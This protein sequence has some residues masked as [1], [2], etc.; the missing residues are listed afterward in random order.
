MLRQILI[1]HSSDAVAGEL[2]GVITA[3]VSDAS[4]IIADTVEQAIETIRMFNIHLILFDVEAADDSLV[5]TYHKVQ[6]AGSGKITPFLL[7]TEQNQTEEVED[8][9]NAG[10]NGCLKLPCEDSDLSWQIDSLCN[11]ERLRGAKRYSIPRTEVSVAQGEHHLSGR[12]VNISE[13]GLLCQLENPANFDWT[14]PFNLGF[15]FNNDVVPQELVDIS[16]ILVSLNVMRANPDNTPAQI[17]AAFRF[18]NVCPM[19]KQE[20]RDIFANYEMEHL[21]IL[22]AM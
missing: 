14:Q 6:S 2:D 18:V 4:V 12:V 9:L 8:A 10:A 19:A 22:Q 13:G 3:N 7:L 5:D 21:S 16:G 15:T 1:V 11:P 17:N 20:L